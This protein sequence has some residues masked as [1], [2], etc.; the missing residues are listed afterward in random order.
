MGAAVEPLPLPRV[1]EPEVGAAVDDHHVVGQLGRDLARLAVGQAQEDHVVPREGL[2]VG[3]AEHPIGQR[4]QVRLQ[5]PE[6]LAGVRAA[7][8]RAD[9]DAGVT[10]QEAQHLTPG[11]PAGTGDRDPLQL[12]VHDYTQA[13][14]IMRSGLAAAE[15]CPCIGSAA[16]SS[17]LA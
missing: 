13:C 7:G 9:L 15:Q 6:R 8:E 10:E 3:G 4:H 17:F 11:V 12:H 2:E 1:G 5:G 14:M 16:G